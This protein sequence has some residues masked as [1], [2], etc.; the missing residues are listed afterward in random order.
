MNS[1][2]VNSDLNIVVTID[3]F[4]W[5]GLK[6]VTPLPAVHF[7]VGILGQSLDLPDQRRLHVG[8]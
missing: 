5:S 7:A 1:A 3:S 4:M 8:G 2:I 6:E